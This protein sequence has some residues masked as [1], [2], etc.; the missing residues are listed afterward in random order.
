MHKLL[1]FIIPCYRSEKTIDLVVKE[2]IDVVREKPLYDYEIIC[3]N[4]FSPDNVYQKLK[5]LATQ[6]ARDIGNDNFISKIPSLIDSIQDAIADI[7]LK[8]LPSSLVASYSNKD[9]EDSLIQLKEQMLRRKDDVEK[10]IEDIESQ[11]ISEKDNN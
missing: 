3:I 1:S 2:I 4:D 7:F 5:E 8:P 9:I 11:N 10:L 6:N